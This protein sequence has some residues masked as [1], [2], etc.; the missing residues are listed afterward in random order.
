M[1]CILCVCI[2]VI[3]N[4]VFMAFFSLMM[5]HQICLSHKGALDLENAKKNL[6]HFSGS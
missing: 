5:E 4:I 2:N 3:H 6:V 1:C